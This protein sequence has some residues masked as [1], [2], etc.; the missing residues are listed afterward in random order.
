MEECVEYLQQKKEEHTTVFFD[1]LMVKF[2]LTAIQ[3]RRCIDIVYN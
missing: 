2:N 1:E 3:V